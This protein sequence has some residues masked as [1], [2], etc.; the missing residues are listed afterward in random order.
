MQVSNFCLFPQHL[1]KSIGVFVLSEEISQGL[2]IVPLAMLT[3]E[4]VWLKLIAFML[5]TSKVPSK[6]DYS[7]EVTF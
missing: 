6:S 4:T 1:K 2:C 3:A 7:N 5:L